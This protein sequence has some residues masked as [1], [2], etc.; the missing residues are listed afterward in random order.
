MKRWALLI[1]FTLLFSVSVNAAGLSLTTKVLDN[2]IMIGEEAVFD[3]TIKND[4]TT[5]DKVTFIISDLDWE[6]EKQTFD[7]NPGNSETFRLRIKAP[8]GVIKSGLYSLNLKV[9]S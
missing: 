1:L 9:Y 6:W 4:Q 3:I 5:A 8:E 7:I 2:L